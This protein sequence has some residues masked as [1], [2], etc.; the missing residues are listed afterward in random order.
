LNSREQKFF[1]GLSKAHK[2]VIF[3]LAILT[4]TS[5]SIA[6]IERLAPKPPKRANL[7]LLLDINDQTEW[8]FTSNFT[9]FS[10]NFTVSNVGNAPA[11]IKRFELWIMYRLPSG[12]F[13]SIPTI[14]ENLSSD[15]G[16]KEVLKDPQRAK[17]WGENGRKRV[18][19]Y[20]TWRKVAEQTLN[21][22]KSLL[23]AGN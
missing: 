17:V 1:T 7:R 12:N 6:L 19:E 21:I 11:L 2:I 22:Y 20:F 14:Y 9:E 4:I 23:A 5:T 15:W 13:Y 18:L 10:V 8:D 16:I 3:L